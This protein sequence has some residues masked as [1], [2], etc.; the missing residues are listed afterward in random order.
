MYISKALNEMKKIFSEVPYGVE[1]TL[2]VLKYAEDIMDGENLNSNRRE[3]I[4]IVVI[5]HDIGAIEAQKKYGSMDAAYQEKEGPVIAR[6]ILNEMNYPPKAIDR[7]CYIIGN[8]HTPSK[9]DGI[10]FQIQWEADMLDN[11]K[12]TNFGNGQDK[13]L[14]YINKNF[15]TATGRKIA[16][17]ELLGE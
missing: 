17:R 1:H 3:L 10:D 16:N 9:I 15:K 12:H 4:S 13:M 14:D 11:L 2:R 8:H 5:L 7:I 6:K